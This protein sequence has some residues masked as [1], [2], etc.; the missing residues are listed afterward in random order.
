MRFDLLH[1]VCFQEKAQSDLVQI[2][3]IINYCVSACV[4]QPVVT[5]LVMHL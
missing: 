4:G 3:C 2:N 1:V 5:T